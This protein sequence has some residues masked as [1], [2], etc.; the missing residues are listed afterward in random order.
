MASRRQTGNG[1]LPWLG[2]NIVKG[3]KF[4]PADGIYSQR[5]ETSERQQTQSQR[6]SVDDLPDWRTF[7]VRESPAP[8]TSGMS[9]NG[10]R[11]ALF[12]GPAGYTQFS[13][14]PKLTDIL[15]YENHSYV[16]L[17]FTKLFYLVEWKTGNNFPFGN[18]FKYQT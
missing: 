1:G 15:Y 7:S 14:F 5:R 11:A 13:I 10:I 16:I 6:W 18:K 8:R 12:M 4:R 9:Q 3:R 2:G 17:K